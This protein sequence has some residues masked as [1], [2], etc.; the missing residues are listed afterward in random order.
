[1]WV[2]INWRKLK[3]FKTFSILV[4]VMVILYSSTVPKAQANVNAELAKKGAAGVIATAVMLEVAGELGWKMTKEAWKKM[5][6]KAKK[7]FEDAYE[8]FDF[9]KKKPKKNGKHI[10]VDVSSLDK[11]KF[12]TIL[13]EIGDEVIEL[14]KTRT[15]K[16]M[17]RPKYEIEVEVADPFYKTGVEIEF[18]INGASSDYEA[19]DAITRLYS[20][21][22]TPMAFKQTTEVRIYSVIDGS[23]AMIEVPGGYP[24]KSY[25]FRAMNEYLSG[26]GYSIAMFENNLTTRKNMYLTYIG[27]TNR[28]STGA[29]EIASKTGKTYQA[30]QS[31]LR[32]LERANMTY[33][34]AEGLM[35]PEDNTKVYKIPT[36]TPSDYQLPGDLNKTGGIFKIPLPDTSDDTVIDLEWEILEQEYNLTNQIDNDYETN[37]FNNVENTYNS[38]TYITNNYYTIQEGEKPQVDI[39]QEIEIIVKPGDGGVIVPGEDVDGLN[40]G[41]IGY[42]KQTYEYISDGIDNSLAS[43]KDV[44][45]SASG[46]VE[47]LD[48]SMDWLPDSWRVLFGSAFILG[49]VAHFLRR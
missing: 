10:D 11:A 25:D 2:N 3:F 30:Y 35:V 19:L 47:F 5:M 37:Y 48:E 26:K 38:T 39:D 7:K 45:D 42:A 33:Y 13:K 24:M 40:R 46:V 1:M 16:N 23:G 29:F 4:V 12:A 49:V 20:V 22:F 32:A 44:T 31:Y 14:D 28:M 21:S 27:S 41:L 8:S 15:G 34:I 18:G 9:P 6:P 43:L 36:N 17:T